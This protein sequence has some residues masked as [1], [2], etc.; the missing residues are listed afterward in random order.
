LCKP[1]TTTEATSNFELAEVFRNET[2]LLQSQLLL[3]HQLVT[4]SSIHVKKRYE[5]LC[6]PGTT[7]EATS[8][9]E[10]AEV[11]RTETKFLQSQLLLLHQLVT[12]SSIHVKRRY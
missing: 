6:K 8:N 10:L 7:T 11:F 2:K 1:A 3:L 9:F 12:L 5:L 4:L